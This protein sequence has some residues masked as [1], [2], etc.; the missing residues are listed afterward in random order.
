MIRKFLFFLCSC[1]I[2]QVHLVAQNGWTPYYTGSNQQYYGIGAYS[3]T[4][5]VAVGASGVINYTADHGVTWNLQNSTT[6]MPLNDVDCPTAAIAYIV[7][8]SGIILKTSNSGATWIRQTS[9]TFMPIRSVHFRSSTVGFACG[10]AGN[11]FSTT[12]GGTTWSMQTVSLSANFN[13]VYF[14]SSQ[15]GYCVGMAGVIYATT[16]GGSTWLPQTSGT[17][18]TL[19]EV[20][21][22]STTSGYAVGTNGVLLTTT[23]GG[24]TWNPGTAFTSYSIEAL[25]FMTTQ[26]GFCNTSANEAF[27]TSDGGVTWTTMSAPA[28]SVTDIELC[29]AVDAVGSAN[30]GYVVESVNTDWSSSVNSTNSVLTSFVNDTLGYMHYSTGIAKTTDGVNW[31]SIYSPSSTYFY[32]IE[33]ATDSVGYVVSQNAIHK[34]VD[35]GQNWT[36]IPTSATFSDLHFLSPDTG[37]GYESGLQR[38]Y[39]GGITWNLVNATV[40]GGSAYRFFDQ[41]TAYMMNGNGLHFT[42]D[43]GVTWIPLFPDGDKLS[44]ANKNYGVVWS[45]S[46]TTI[47][48]TNNGGRS[49]IPL[50][51]PLAGEVL[52]D[53]VYVDSVTM[54][55]AGHLSSNNYPRIYKSTNG[56]HTWILQS[57]T[58]TNGISMLFDFPDKNHG[59]CATP[60]GILRNVNADSVFADNTGRIPDGYIRGPAPGIS[61]SRHPIDPVFPYGPIEHSYY[62]E[63]EV[64]YSGNV[65]VAGNFDDETALD[66]IYIG[67]NLNFGFF[68][69]KLTTTGSIIWLQYFLGGNGIT[70]SLVVDK[71]NDIIVSGT[72]SNSITIGTNT[73][74]T[75]G[76]GTYVAKLDSLG[77]VIWSIGYDANPPAFVYQD[78]VLDDSGNVYMVGNYGAPFNFQSYSFP[79]SGGCYIVKLDPSGNL[80]WANYSSDGVNTEATSCAWSPDGQLVVCG[81]YNTTCSFN[82]QTVQTTDNREMF[83]AKFDSGT[84]VIVWLQNAYGYADDE[85]TSVVCDP[86]SNIYMTGLFSYECRFDSLHWLFSYRNEGT[87]LCKYSPNGDVIYSQ[88]WNYVYG[89]QITTDTAGNCY[90]AAT[91]MDER[92]FSDTLVT[93][94]YAYQTFVTKLDPVGK[95]LF[96]N[97]IR[98]AVPFSAT[99]DYVI[100]EDIEVSVSGDIYVSGNERGYSIDS[101]GN[102]SG[103]NALILYGFIT[104]FGA[105]NS[106]TVGLSQ[107][108]FA[109]VSQLIV[110]PNPANSEL[111]I[112]LPGEKAEFTVQIVNAYGEIVNEVQLLNSTTCVLS[113]AGYA[114][115][116]YFV[117]V[118][119]NSG[120]VTHPFTVIH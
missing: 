55:I 23:N 45:S 46:A 38:T 120:V 41:D 108:T 107:D 12:N 118:F 5:W 77:N 37:F 21:F 8:D 31:T 70:R 71:N 35:G 40:I 84:G 83:L 101:L 17:T 30:F 19:N 87:F 100:F 39:D 114:P 10:W 97:T 11:I 76:T 66:S 53:V 29:T 109:A 56:G 32:D 13:D 16:D 104:K 115:G 49:F 78:I 80:I 79:V 116:V 52:R 111:I 58:Y 90:M 48:K 82:N 61:W 69:A 22:T 51:H 47:Y 42:S 6:G 95:L 74:T 15:V 25:L 24:V 65:I 26:I 99:Y 105:L 28:F 103:G 73:F 4:T 119:T 33:F 27:M 3:S 57:C 72:F 20:H 14:A 7:G 110:Y 113:V 36:V 117:N 92:Y 59:Y 112:S 64:D 9:G 96:I 44:F 50:D 88:A 81:K 63:T 91:V 86:N 18:E 1:V 34:T 62:G 93:P 89:S 75:T 94:Q 67:P 68:V 85:A 2:A 60:Q 54:Y 102:F 43:A 106:A 98:G